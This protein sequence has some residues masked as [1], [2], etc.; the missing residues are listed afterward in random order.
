MRPRTQIGV[1]S[2]RQLAR[3]GPDHV[4]EVA[5]LAARMIAAGTAW[6]RPEAEMWGRLWLID[7]YWYA[8]RLAEIA[9]SCHGCSGPPSRWAASH[10]GTLLVTRALA[11]ARAE[12]DDADRLVREAVDHFERLGHPAAHGASVSFRLLLG[13]H[14]GN[15]RRC[16]RR[17]PGTLVRMVAGISPAG[18]FEA[19]A[20]VDAQ[21]L[22]EAAAVYQRCGVPE[23]WEVAPMF[24][25]VGLAVGA[26]VAAALGLGDDTQELR[27]RLTPYRGQYVVGGAGGPTSSV[28]S[29]SRSASARRRW[30]TG[31][32]RGSSSPQRVH[33]AGRSARR[34]S[35]SRPTAS[36]RPHW[37]KPATARQPPGS[38][39]ARSHSQV[40]SA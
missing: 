22:D 8:G 17:S 34:A 30:P 21:R 37:R 9:A 31:I 36:S 15:P 13:H 1:L 23:G 18:S 10:A 26:Q 2:S 12:F 4:V 29:S 14:R 32:P 27:E 20:L 35:R 39:S 19:F 24:R 38:R 11:L 40:P 5:S 16:C 6:R 7:T 25:L 3:S 28:P 33:C